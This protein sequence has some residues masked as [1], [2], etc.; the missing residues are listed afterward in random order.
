MV[1][2][3][4]NL[5]ESMRT[6]ILSLLLSLTSLLA[7][8]SVIIS[9]K[10][11][12]DGRPLMWKHRDTGTLENKLMFFADGKYDYQGIVNSDDELGEQIWMG[13]NSA[14]FGI[15]NTA[16][17][18][19]NINDTC[20]VQDR[21]GYVMRMALKVCA[22][23]DDF[24]NF[25]DTLKKPMGV[26]ANFGV[27]DAQGGAAFF[28]T[29]NY[30]F[31][32][33]DVNDQRVAP[34]GYIVR[35]NYSFTG[36]EDDG[37]GY[38][39]FLSTEGLFYEESATHTFSVETI[40]N[41]GTRNLYN[42]LTEVDLRDIQPKDDSKAKFVVMQDY[43]PRSS[44]ASSMIL[45][46]VKEGEAP[47][48]TTMWTVLGFQLC[49]VAIPTWMVGTDNLP[50]VLIADET[51]FAPLNKWTMEIKNR[52][53]FP[54]KRGSGS[55]YM[56]LAKVINRNKTG[57]LQKIKPLEDLIFD[58]TERNLN[59]WRETE[60]PEEEIEDFYRWVDK[61]VTEEYQKMLNNRL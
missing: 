8:T 27:I 20:S 12:V 60:M 21:E 50:N 46:G 53:L 51:G 9:G 54:I 16:S 44:S 37:Y 2:Y 35:T 6:F 7:C 3:I 47:K 36:T 52:D 22:T 17:Y 56:N 42:S 38:V 23:V 61:T 41:K 30:K 4:H 55:K 1:N 31:E 10:Y 14:G 48:F 40:L 5:G 33:F 18:N 13:F 11:T 39:R 19:L 34:F 25:L 15:M 58:F 49:T 29:G 28:E 26:A 24:E 57:T 59:K 45:Q 43:I 32:K